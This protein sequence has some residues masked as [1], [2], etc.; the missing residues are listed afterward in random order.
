MSLVVPLRVVMLC[1]LTHDVPQMA[2]TE[3]DYRRETFRLG[4]SK[5]TLCIGIQLRAAWRP[6]VIPARSNTPAHLSLLVLPERFD[7]D[8]LANE[9]EMLN[10]SLDMD[11]EHL[12][13]LPPFVLGERVSIRP[14]R[15]DR[16]DGGTR[17]KAIPACI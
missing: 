2:L 16:S 14:A 13:E 12:I 3:R 10:M 15:R 17:S 6:L 1:V 5:E 11:S 9:T 7:D 4:R 8:A